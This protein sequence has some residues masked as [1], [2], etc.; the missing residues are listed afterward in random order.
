MRKAPEQPYGV[1]IYTVDGMF[2]KQMVI[3]KTGTLVPTHAHAWDHVSML[4]IGAVK[5]WRD[6]VG[7]EIVHA[8]TGIF[9]KAGVKHA[10]LAL[11]DNTIIFCVHNLHSEAAV[12]VLE[13]HDL[14]LEC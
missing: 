7:G 5:I 12:K 10:F 3:P 14:A 1:E 2:I 9:I 13:E 8:P 6:G 11:E 4:A